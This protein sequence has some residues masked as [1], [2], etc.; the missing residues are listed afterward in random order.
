LILVAAQVK[1]LVA[2]RLDTGWWLEMSNSWWL[3]RLDTVLVA[4]EV[5]LLVAIKIKLL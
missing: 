3:G 5:K 1:L 2:E 4:G